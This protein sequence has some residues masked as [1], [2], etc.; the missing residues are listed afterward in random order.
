MADATDEDI[1]H[2]E[3]LVAILRRRQRVL[4]IQRARYDSDNPPTHLV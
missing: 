1:A 2:L 3:Q 4:E